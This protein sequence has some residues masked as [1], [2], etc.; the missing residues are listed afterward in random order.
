MR[1][2][3]IRSKA[4]SHPLDI[5]KT[6][7]LKAVPPSTTFQTSKP[8]F[9]K[10]TSL[11]RSASDKYPKPYIPKHPLIQNPETSHQQAYPVYLQRSLDHMKRY[12]QY[13]NENKVQGCL[14][15]KKIQSGWTSPSAVLFRGATRTP[16]FGLWVEREVVVSASETYPAGLAPCVLKKSEYLDWPEKLKAW[17]ESVE[18]EQDL[19]TA[20]EN[21]FVC[22][23]ID[24]ILQW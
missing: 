2:N 13:I 18:Q 11:D 12:W 7:I 9:H 10:A 1:L 24:C 16:R 20:G 22:L 5:K 19:H 3:D 23:L 15:G 14:G 17:V 4:V 6:G 21:P 8:T